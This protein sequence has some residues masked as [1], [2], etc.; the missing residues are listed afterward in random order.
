MD[1]DP[2]VWTASAERPSKIGLWAALTPIA[3]VA[4]AVVAWVYA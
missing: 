2:K 3:L 1:R 4:I